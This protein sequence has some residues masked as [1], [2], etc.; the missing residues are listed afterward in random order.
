MSRPT[1][2]PATNSEKMPPQGRKG[3][4]SSRN[5]RRNRKAKRPVATVGMPSRIS[6]IGLMTLRARPGVLGEVD[7][8]AQADGNGDR[9]GDDG[10]E[11][12]AHEDRQDTEGGV[13]ERR[14][15]HAC[16]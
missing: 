7:G 13:G 14:L 4:T 1:P 5:G 15:P 2:M 16:R 10:H 6:R 9:Q 8:A 3:S 12:G 11:Q